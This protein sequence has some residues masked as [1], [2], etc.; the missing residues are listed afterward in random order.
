VACFLAS[1]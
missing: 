1:F